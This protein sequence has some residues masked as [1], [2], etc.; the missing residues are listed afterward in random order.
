MLLET[1]ETTRQTLQAALQQSQQQLSSCESK[2][3]HFTNSLVPTQLHNKLTSLNHNPYTQTFN[4]S[5]IVI[6][7]AQA[8]DSK[9][10]L[11]AIQRLDEMLQ[12]ICERCNGFKFDVRLGCSCL[13]FLPGTECGKTVQTALEAAFDIL[14]TTRRLDRQDHHNGSRVHIGAH[15]GNVDLAIFH[16]TIPRTI[17]RGDVI[18][19]AVE[20]SQN[21]AEDAILM[22]AQMKRK[23]GKETKYFT[24]KHMTNI[25]NV[26]KTFF[27]M[28]KIILL[29]I[30][31]IL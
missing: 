18:D 4:C 12:N 29:C 8:T 7:I 30:G 20:L 14:E 13:L 25:A 9:I 10:Y 1:S 28:L 31:K 16:N 23:L 27:S 26:S 17:A 6:K 15:C 19:Q 5:L 3:R 2:L 24:M 21:A 22:S 11:K